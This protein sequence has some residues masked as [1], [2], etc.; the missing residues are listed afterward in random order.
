MKEYADTPD[1]DAR[2][3]EEEQDLDEWFWRAGLG[4]TTTSSRLQRT[5]TNDP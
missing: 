2:L 1:L 4:S 5:L 3:E